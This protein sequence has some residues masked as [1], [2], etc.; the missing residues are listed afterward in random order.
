MEEGEKQK[1]QSLTITF[2]WG[3]MSSVLLEGNT[4]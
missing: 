3:E 1:Y 4:M 2:G